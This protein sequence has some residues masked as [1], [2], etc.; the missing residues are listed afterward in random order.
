MRRCEPWD[1]H[2]PRSLFPET[3]GGSNSHTAYIP[4]EDPGSFAIVRG[5]SCRRQILGAQSAA[6]IIKTKAHCLE[7]FQ[8]EVRRA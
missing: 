3:T 4:A 8:R 2:R 6:L 1:A 5:V 7:V